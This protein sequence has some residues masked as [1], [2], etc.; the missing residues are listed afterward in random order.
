MQPRLTVEKAFFSPACVSKSSIAPEAFSK[1]K[2]RTGIKLGVK[3]HHR[4]RLRS[5]SVQIDKLH[6]RLAPMQANATLSMQPI[7]L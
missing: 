2:L 4:E 3:A 1:A 7:A 6:L 5:M